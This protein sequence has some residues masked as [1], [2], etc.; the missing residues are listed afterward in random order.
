MSYSIN[1]RA[2]N[3][4]ALKEKVDAAITAQVAPQQPHAERDISMIRAT[5]AGVIDSLDEP[6][7]GYELVLE[8]YGS[9]SGEWSDGKF[10]SYTSNSINCRTYR[11]PAAIPA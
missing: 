11:A 7:D 1:A 6:G 4:A 5:C 3:K 9:M 2:A 10:V 8:C